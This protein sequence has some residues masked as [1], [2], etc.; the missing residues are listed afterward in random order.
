MLTNPIINLIVLLLMSNYAINPAPTSNPTL[1]RVGYVSELDGLEREYFVYLPKGYHT[2]P[3]KIWP[4]MLFLHG[5][6]E[7]GNGLDELDYV[8]IHGPLSEA[9]VQKRDLPFIIIVPQLHIFDIDKVEGSEGLKN[10]T[11][12]IIPRRQKDGAP[13]RLEAAKLNFEMEGATPAADMPQEPIFLE[14]GWNNVENDLLGMLD[15]V[16]GN[17]NTDKSRVYLT[18][19]SYGGFGTWYMASKHPE[20][21]AA[22]SPVV[23]WLHPSLV[24]PLAEANMPIW[25]FAGGRDKVVELKYFFEGMNLLE[26]QG[27]TN[28][29]FTVHEDM[30]HD[31]WK[32]IYAGE[33]IYNWFLEH[34]LD[35]E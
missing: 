9:W 8:M 10:R 2:E 6:G 13:P 31:A 33:D 28:I 34:S 22:I 26:K 17:Y 4:V 24:A 11:T 5:T 12:D 14:Y 19:I 29:R 1:E 21:F 25:A 30:G 27:N 3:D 7:R 35:E 16:L 15:H 20:R 23:G 32:R 18:G